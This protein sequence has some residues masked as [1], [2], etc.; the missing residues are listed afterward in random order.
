MKKTIFTCDICE[1]EFTNEMF[2]I[3]AGTT[4]KMFEDGIRTGQF[5]GHYCHEC[6]S[7]ILLQIDHLK[8]D[9]K[10]TGTDQ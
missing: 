1:K 6:T 10:P 7:K 2:S 8:N 5:E 3:Y 9:V 4:Q